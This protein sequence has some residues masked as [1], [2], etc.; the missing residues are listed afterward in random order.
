MYKNR[1][2]GLI[3]A[4]KFIFQDY[5]QILRIIARPVKDNKMAKIKNFSVALPGLDLEHSIKTTIKK[6]SFAGPNLW[7]KILIVSI[8]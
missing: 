7:R 5:F 6:I 8:E 3:S 2:F 4:I 1:A